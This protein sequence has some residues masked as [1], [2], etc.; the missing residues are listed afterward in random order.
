MSKTIL[1]VQGM[2]CASCVQQLNEALAI[3]GVTSV[4]VQLD[5]GV[6]AV[7]HDTSV[8]AERLIGALQGAGYAAALQSPS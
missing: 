5:E 7:D 2:S 8:S 3:R 1:T 6:V 4:D